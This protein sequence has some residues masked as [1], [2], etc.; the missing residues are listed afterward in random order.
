MQMKGLYH[1]LSPSGA[2]TGETLLLPF[3]PTAEFSEDRGALK[4][5]DM[6]TEFHY[7]FLSQCK[8]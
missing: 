4:A 6:G 8:T 2:K 5:R 7:V 3:L 1:L